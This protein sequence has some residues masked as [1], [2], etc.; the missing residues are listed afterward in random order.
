[1][2]QLRREAYFYTVFVKILAST[3]KKSSLFITLSYNELFSCIFFFQILSFSSFFLSPLS[4]FLI[5]MCDRPSAR[6][7]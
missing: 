5:F 3:L 6:P 7:L 2:A 4:F 1:M